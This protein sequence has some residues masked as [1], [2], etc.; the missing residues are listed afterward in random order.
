MS[1]YNSA[2]AK[3]V[4]LIDQSIQSFSKLVGVLMALHPNKF[5]WSLFH[6]FFV[7]LRKEYTKSIGK[8]SVEIIA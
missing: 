7:T 1:K 8:E 3:C 6:L 5:I 4:I 2:V